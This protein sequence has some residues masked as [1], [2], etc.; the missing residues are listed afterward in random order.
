MSNLPSLSLDNWH[1]IERT[2]FIE[3]GRCQCKKLI[4]SGTY[5]NFQ[6]IDGGGGRGVVMNLLMTDTDLGPRQMHKGMD[7]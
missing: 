4:I 3:E 5:Q 7:E 6:L 1:T 2:L